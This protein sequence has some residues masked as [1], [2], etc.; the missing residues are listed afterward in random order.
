MSENHLVNHNSGEQNVAPTAIE[1]VDPDQDRMAEA[2]Q[3]DLESGRQGTMT[4]FFKPKAQVKTQAK[5]KAKSISTKIKKASTHVQSAFPKPQSQPQNQKQSLILLEEVDVLFK[6]DESFWATVIK[7]AT[8]SKRP[9]V[10]TCNDESLI[11]LNALPLHAILRLCPPPADLAADYLLLLAAKEGHLLE[12]R[13]VSDLYRS[14]DHDLRASI[15]ELDFW[16]QMSVGDR[17]GGL[18]WIYQRWPPGKDVDEHGRILRVASKGTYKSGMGWLS[19]DVIQSSD[20]LAFDKEEE[21]L[22]EAWCMWGIS[23]ECWAHPPNDVQ[24]MHSG[25]AVRRKI[26]TLQQLEDLLECVSAADTY[27][28]VGLPFNDM[29]P[30]DPTQPLMP[31]NAAQNFTEVHSLL[32]ADPLEDPTAFAEKLYVRTHLAAQRAAASYSLSYFEDIRTTYYSD[33]SAPETYTGAILAH[34]A[35]IRTTTDLT[36]WDFAEALDPLAIPPAN[37]LTHA[38]PSS[39]IASSFDREFRVI[40]EDLAPYARSIVKHEQKLEI[41]RVRMS[42]LLSE[43][44]RAKRQ[45]TSRASRSALEG[46][47]REEKRRERWFTKELNMDL[48]MATGGKGWAG[49][50]TEVESLASDSRRSG[51]VRTVISEDEE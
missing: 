11:A 16:C 39:L 35:S 50:G 8:Q 34:K 29:D 20:W 21:L 38:A 40:V 41:E 15:T 19:H 3:K 18:E 32:Q 42:N 37:A 6:E 28:R 46:G 17:K 10:M 23:P 12:R 5:P 13:A 9:I 31:R 51:S 27:C 43:G 14:K 2:L 1:A 36:R 49:M 48:V 45:R 4:S 26:K 47:K 24:E 22:T 25:S 30:M 7:L 44:G 33:P